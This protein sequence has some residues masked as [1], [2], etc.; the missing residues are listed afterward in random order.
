MDDHRIYHKEKSPPTL[1]ENM[2]P[3]P[4]EKNLNPPHKKTGKNSK[5]GPPLPNRKQSKTNSIILTF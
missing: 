4:K 2:P 1:K 5:K 3:P